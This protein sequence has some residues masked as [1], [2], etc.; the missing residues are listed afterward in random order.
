MKVQKWIF[1]TLLGEK[2]FLQLL[3]G[4]EKH[5]FV[6]LRLRFHY[7]PPVKY[8]YLYHTYCH[9]KCSYS[10]YPFQSTIFWEILTSYLIN[11]NHFMFYVPLFL[12]EWSLFSVGILFFHVLR[13]FKL[14]HKFQEHCSPSFRTSCFNF[15]C[16]YNLCMLNTDFL[17]MDWQ[18]NALFS[19]SFILCISTE[20]LKNI[21]IKR[22]WGMRVWYSIFQ[23][24]CM[25]YHVYN[26]MSSI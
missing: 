19:R 1:S 25:V 6:G 21:Y 13:R 8:S 9:K 24:K 10:W 4:N 2:C 20:G 16:G 22:V 11:K 5:F 14:F 26:M 15:H 17:C 3:S 23:T 12:T 7:F 18:K